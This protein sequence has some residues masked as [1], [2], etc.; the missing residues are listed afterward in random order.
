MKA[1]KQI[2]SYVEKIYRKNTSY[3]NTNFKHHIYKRFSFSIFLKRL[4]KENIIIKVTDDA[5]LAT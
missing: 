4:S 5:F 1:L 3:L 2:N